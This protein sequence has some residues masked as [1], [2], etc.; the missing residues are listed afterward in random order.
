MHWLCIVNTGLKVLRRHGEDERAAVG[1]VQCDRCIPWSGVAMPAGNTFEARGMRSRSEVFSE[2]V[3]P[4][5]MGQ[6][7]RRLE[8]CRE[9]SSS[10]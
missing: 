2:L 3:G 1:Q 5:V 4:G 9:A 6:R 8:D 10:M 7:C